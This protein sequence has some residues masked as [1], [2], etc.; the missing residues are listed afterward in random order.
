MLGFSSGKSTPCA[1]FFR[2]QRT[3]MQHFIFLRSRDLTML[4]HK[5]VTKL[6]NEVTGLRAEKA[7]L[8]YKCFFSRD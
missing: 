3:E 7:K 2:L 1:S 5:T 8:E 4:E 6:E